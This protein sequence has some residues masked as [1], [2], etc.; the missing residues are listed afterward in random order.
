VPFVFAGVRGQS[1]PT[2]SLFDST[3]FGRYMA[4]SGAIDPL[5][6]GVEIE[7]GTRHDFTGRTQALLARQDFDTML[8]LGNSVSVGLTPFSVDY[9]AGS[10][11]PER[12]DAVSRALRVDWFEPLHGSRISV[13]LWG[14]GEYSWL[15]QQL[16]WS[17]G[18]GISGGLLEHS[19]ATVHRRYGPKHKATAGGEEVEWYPPAPW[20][21][22]IRSSSGPI[23]LG[24][25][26]GAT[27]GEDAG[28][29][30]EG[31]Q[32]EFMKRNW[33]GA[34]NPLSF[35]VLFEDVLEFTENR[36]PHTSLSLFGSGRWY[37]FRPLGILVDAGGNTEDLSP[38]HLHPWSVQGK[39]GLVLTI[40]HLDLI[41]E[42]PTIPRYDWVSNEI[43]SARIALEGFAL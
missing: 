17:A 18:L 1:V 41:V 33:W 22:E 36:A 13:S 4:T 35:G 21:S 12:F 28:K 25:Y 34:L 32:L 8:S 31:V 39:A 38:A 20:D 16:R 42:S 29:V 30:R 40:G 3:I 15:D 6:L 23:L 9:S 11:L 10:G 19:P 2:L 26:V 24:G 43:V 7:V 27:S 5:T 37:V 14:P